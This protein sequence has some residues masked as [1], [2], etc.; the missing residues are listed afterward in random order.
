MRF[1]DFISQ[2]NKIYEIEQS[3]SG[4]RSE[5]MEMVLNI[6]QK[7]NN[8]LVLDEVLNLVMINAIRLAQADRGFYSSWMTPMN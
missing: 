2:Q 6:I 4:T 3:S 5:N 7:I 8:S 1:A